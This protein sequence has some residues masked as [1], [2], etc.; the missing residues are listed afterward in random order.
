M[1]QEQCDEIPLNGIPDTLDLQ[2]VGWMMLSIIQ[3]GK[4]LTPY[5]SD[6]PLGD[7]IL[8]EVS[9]AARAA[10]LCVWMGGRE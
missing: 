2:E 3:P 8:K 9:I 7:S 6:E 1:S 5:Q 4:D 10:F